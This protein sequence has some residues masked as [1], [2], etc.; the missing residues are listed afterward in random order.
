MGDFNAGPN[1]NFGELISQ[2]CL[3]HG[4]KKSDKIILPIDSFTYVSDTH[5]TCSW[6]DHVVPSKSK[7]AHDSNQNIKIL[8]QF[9]LSDHRPVA[10]TIKTAAIPQN[11]LCEN[12]TTWKKDE[13]EQSHTATKT[14]ISTG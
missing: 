3:E 1:N 10:A 8:H 14:E 4:L 13:L 5:G 11:L 2:F 12:K 7:S 6:L 9:I